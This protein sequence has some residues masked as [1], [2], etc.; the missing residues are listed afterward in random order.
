MRSQPKHQ[1]I[2]AF[3]QER[4]K[5]LSLKIFAVGAVSTFFISLLFGAYYY[6]S[7]LS[8]TLSVVSKSLSQPVALGG[9]FL[10]T[11]VVKTLVKSG[12]F[13]D[14]WVT[15]PNGKV[16]VNEHRYQSYQDLAKIGNKGY[17]WRKGMPHVLAS[18]PILHLNSRIGTLHVG[19]Q[20]PVL[21]IFGFAMLICVLFSLLSLYLYRRILKL[22]E[23]VSV[24]LHKYA[25]ELDSSEDKENFL[26]SNHGL[27]RFSEI[28]KFNKILLNYIKKSKANE[29]IARK[30][31]SKAQVAK[32]ATRVR[33]DVIASLTVGEA[34]LERLDQR[35]EQVK[36][37][38]S[39][40]ERVNNTVADIPEIGGLTE[41]EMR[42]AAVGDNA[43]TKIDDEVRSCHVSAFVY[44][45]VGEIKLS[46]LCV[47][48][49]IKFDVSCNREGFGAYCAVA[50][51]KF[52]RD[53]MNL[54][55]NAVEAIETTGIVKTRVSVV[56]YAVSIV[57]SDNGKGIAAE[58]LHKVGNRGVTIGKDGGTGIGLSSAIEDVHRWG[59]TLN[60]SSPTGKG[61][62]VEIILPQTEENLLYP[63]SLAF[64][65]HMT[66]VVVDDDPLIHKLW[67]NRFAP[68][69]L[70]EHNI[71][72]LYA[73]HLHAAKKIII[74]LEGKG[75]DYI[76]LIDHD[77]GSTSPTGIDFVKQMQ[78]AT[79]SILVTSNG[80][81]S[82]LYKKCSQIG[83]AIVPKV[84]QERI[85]IE[86]GA[87]TGEEVNSTT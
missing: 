25:K 62:A 3:A 48:K 45:I 12:N 72:T 57:I 11:Q 64:A 76:L 63:V 4:A 29:A 40:F 53:L 68:L 2:T 22:A 38:K 60:V 74:E 18:E 51:N 78:I 39:A 36:V 41:D 81:S 70:E 26:Q 55:K 24:P 87:L 17:Y 84:I 16:Y 85:P 21:A 54:Y 37:L 30:A 43:K 5:S 13:K 66:I 28:C 34:A 33:H 50:P 23:N 52:K 15:L 69:K 1:S 56:D 58:N 27:D 14:A 9:D 20:I 46:K 47:G 67:Q 32:V 82:W 61:V 19:Y 71:E 59:G 80:N 6:H 73:K 49:D 44:Q 75:K 35:D 8:Q 10:P 42:L 77:L 79:R 83:L 65:A 86:V 7:Q 31:I